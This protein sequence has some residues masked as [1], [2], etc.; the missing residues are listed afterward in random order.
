MVWAKLNDEIGDNAKWMAA[1]M[2][3]RGVWTSALAFAARNL[4]DGF[5]PRAWL[6]REV[7]GDPACEADVVAGELVRLRLW[8]EVDGG[9]A[10][11]DYL[12]YNPSR[13]D[14]TEKRRKDSDRKRGHS[15]RNPRGIQPE[16]NDIPALPEPVPETPTA[17]ISRAA[18]DEPDRTMSG[19]GTGTPSVP[20]RLDDRRPIKTQ[21][22]PWDADDSYGEALQAIARHRDALFDAF[23]E[24][25]GIA[26]G[27]PEH[28][29]RRSAAAVELASPDAADLTPERVAALTRYTV[30][31]RVASGFPKTPDL[32]DVLQEASAHDRWLAAGGL[33]DEVGTPVLPRASP[34]SARSA[35]RGRGRQAAGMTP[36]E[37]DE[38]TR[39][40]EAEEAEDATVRR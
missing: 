28:R 18:H 39:R 30:A 8:H 21:P 33:L 15:N 32:A 31:R 20:I 25:A 26:R 38:L 12:D 29:R 5:V 16:S 4:T 34:G 19:E 27:T 37:L 35:G 1:S 22:T 36:E 9:F 23:A 14:I 3:A 2:A 11:H 7:G 17:E 6:V 24:P 13:S 10:I 40:Y